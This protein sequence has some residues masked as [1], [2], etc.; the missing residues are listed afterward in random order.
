[1]PRFER[2]TNSKDGK[3]Y[4]M[5]QGYLGTNEMTGKRVR[6]T[7]RKAPNGEPFRTKKEAKDEMRR[8]VE[9]F[10]AG[11]FDEFKKRDES[12]V[13]TFEQVAS[14]WLEKRYKPTIKAS[15]YLATNDM[16]FKLHILPSIGDY[17][18][19]KI[20][21]NAL[22]TV[23]DK[24]SKALSSHRFKLVVNYTKKVFDY[25]VLE[26]IISISPMH[27]VH[28][29]PTKKST[30]IKPTEFYDKNELHEF[31]TACK[32]YGDVNSLWHTLFHILA[33]TGLRKGEALALTWDDINLKEGYVEVNK[34]TATVM[35]KDGKRKLVIHD[36]TKNGEHRK[37]TIDKLTASLLKAYKLSQPAKTKLVFPAPKDHTKH[38]H[39]QSAGKA[40]KTI[41]V[42]N[43]LKLITTHELR[44]T[45]CSL[46]FEAGVGMK[47]VQ[48]RL[49]HKDI[50]VTM[51][52][53]AHVT[54][55]RSS[56]VAE[57]FSKHVNQNVK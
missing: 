7:R 12:D 34:T 25:A 52:V 44:H 30:P 28:I 26:D 3:Q 33:Y 5:L 43:D 22:E 55:D 27:K 10:N 17:K 45:H 37:V 46:L 29:Q 21:K 19:K 32:E 11:E 9:S 47:E 54:K 8:L 20:D 53:Y 24:W 56:E 36:M 48:Q 42:K 35:G 16:F 23:V 41:I 2:Y 38:M 39:G 6:V 57:L 18:I 51:N 31:L 40:L 13:I 4:W 50:S 1:M 14:E 49:G 15:T